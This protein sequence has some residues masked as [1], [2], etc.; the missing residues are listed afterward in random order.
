MNH[1]IDTFPGRKITIDGVS[2]LYF[3]GTS[4]LGLQTDADF[5]KL[6]I[7]NI[8]KYGTNYG[9]SRKSN[10]RLSVFDK[11][12][13]YLADLV[14]S[15][16]CI[17]LSS[18]YLAGQFL[19]QALNTKAHQFFYAPNT[20]SALYQEKIKPYTT[21][22]AL[23]IAVREHLSSSKTTPVVFLDG[24]DFSGCNYPHFEALQVLPLD[25]ILLVVDDS[26]GLGIVGKNGGGVY[27]IL[28]K[29]NIKE[30]IVCGSLGKGFGI[31]AG[32]IFGT[33]ARLAALADTSFFGGASPATP[34]A[35]ATLLEAD[36]LYGLKRNRLQRNIAYFLD[37][38]KK[39]KQ[40]H[41]MQDHPVFTFSNVQLTEYL[42]A[43]KII[44]TCFPYPDKNAQLMSRIVLSAAHK[45]KDIMHLLECVN[46]LP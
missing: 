12:E 46:I 4:Y 6:F 22:A 25:K 1:Y 17:S 9:A 8:K 41:F 24:I 18:G 36:G 15:E 43:N 28:A 5:Q 20:H 37:H 30:L 13:A 38:L 40:F 44:V 3:G 33:K 10:I 19:A 29:L 45:K 35:M 21:F 31:Q 42:A 16:A 39:R 14:G 2:H 7:K 32:A 27:S 26:H 23:N 11:A 34:A